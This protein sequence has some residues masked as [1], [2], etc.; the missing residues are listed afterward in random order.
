MSIVG[1]QKKSGRPREY[2]MNVAQGNRENMEGA[3]GNWTDREVAQAS[4]EVLRKYGDLL[5]V[6]YHGPREHTPMRVE[7]RAAQFSPFQ[8]LT[9]YG[10]AVE[11]T[12]RLTRPLVELTPERQEEINEG[13]RLIARQLQEHPRQYATARLTYFLED[14][15][16]EGG[17]YLTRT[18][19]VK[20]LDTYEKCVITDL[21]E[22]IPMDHIFDLETG[23]TR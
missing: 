19:S 21:G 22:R 1:T 10:A 7:E 9:G 18:L 3:H 15:R 12:A 17:E 2:N 14:E 16:K 4:S 8:A 23:Q 13:L 5:D 11:E 6:E 20:R